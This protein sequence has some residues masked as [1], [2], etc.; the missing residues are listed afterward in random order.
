MNLLF[1]FSDEI[2][3]E[4]QFDN[5]TENYQFICDKW[6]LCSGLSSNFD[7]FWVNASGQLT[8]DNE[9]FNFSG[10]IILTEIEGETK[11]ICKLVFENSLLKK[12]EMI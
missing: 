5:K 12:I 7:S 1:D 11:E 2:Y 4:P 10:T 6:F 3:I 8:L 9:L